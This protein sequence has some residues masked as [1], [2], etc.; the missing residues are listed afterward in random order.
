M[1]NDLLRY[2]KDIQWPDAMRRTVWMNLMDRM[3]SQGDVNQAEALYNEISAWA[4]SNND[5]ALKAWLRFAGSRL[6]G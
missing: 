4:E 3:A 5:K 1:T 2:F 6:Q